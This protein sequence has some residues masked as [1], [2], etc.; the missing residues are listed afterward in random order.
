MSMALPLDAVHFHRR[1]FRADREPVA[2]PAGP[3]FD[4]HCRD[5][6]RDSFLFSLPQGQVCKPAERVKHC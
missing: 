4:R 6:A 1:W 3:V 2:G 5:T